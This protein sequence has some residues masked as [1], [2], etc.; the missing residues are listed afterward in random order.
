MADDGEAPAPGQPATSDDAAGAGAGVEEELRA[1]VP[2][3]SCG[4]GTGVSFG[5]IDVG[6]GVR[7]GGKIGVSVLLRFGCGFGC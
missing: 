1:C 7:E 5:G 4:G 2:C 6:R 3:A